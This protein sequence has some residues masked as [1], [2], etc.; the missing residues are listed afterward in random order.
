MLS[1]DEKCDDVH[2]IFH[3]FS[4]FALFPC[5]I[6][7]PFDLGVVVS[8]PDKASSLDEGDKSGV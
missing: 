1:I 2:Y 5:D 6:R 4:A 7:F 3:A 8:L